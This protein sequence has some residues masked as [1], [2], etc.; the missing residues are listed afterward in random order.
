MVNR[1]IGRLT[2]SGR[3]AVKAYGAKVKCNQV[4]VNA[5][6]KHRNNIACK[7]NVTHRPRPA[8]MFCSPDS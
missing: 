5:V 8:K 1:E 7:N 2:D 4:E 3:N 6:R